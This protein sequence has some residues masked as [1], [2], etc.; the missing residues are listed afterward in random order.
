[1]ELI[2]FDFQAGKISNYREISIF[3]R[4][5]FYMYNLALLSVKA[6][7]C[8]LRTAYTLFNILVFWRETIR[9]SKPMWNDW[10]NVLFWLCYSFVF[11]AGGKVIVKNVIIFL[12]MYFILSKSGW[13]QFW[14]YM[15]TKEKCSIKLFGVLFSLY[16]QD[17][18]MLWTI[19]WK[20]IK[21]AISAL[22]FL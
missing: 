3:E 17:F 19:Q 20:H 8:T 4:I 21:F 9:K 10:Q 15:L 22:F 5:S 14:L 13:W 1:M 12:Y 6:L 16:T 2:S 7:L 18:V 11:C